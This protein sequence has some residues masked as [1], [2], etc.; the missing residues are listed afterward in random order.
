MICTCERGND[1][2]YQNTL[3]ASLII[4]PGWTFEPPIMSE[5]VV[6]P[7][8]TTTALQYSS[9]KYCVAVFKEEAI[10]AK[11]VCEI[12]MHQT[13]IQTQNCIFKPQIYSFLF[14]PFVKSL[15]K[16]PKSLENSAFCAISC[17][18]VISDK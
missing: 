12:T 8:A 11:V 17:K 2:F 6:A 14:Q 7:R 4:N 18:I 9:L 16:Y 10:A 15:R 3:V 1:D 5:L 13:Q